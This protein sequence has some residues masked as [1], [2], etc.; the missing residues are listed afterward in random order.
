MLVVVEHT[1]K[2]TA[3]ATLN[4]GRRRQASVYVR[5]KYIIDSCVVCLIAVCNSMFSKSYRLL[6]IKSDSTC[7]TGYF[8]IYCFQRWGFLVTRNKKLCYLLSSARRDADNGVTIIPEWTGHYSISSLD[9]SGC[10]IAGKY[11]HSI[12]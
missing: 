3:R 7:F 5:D 10:H 6:K 9:M 1:H 2:H 4:C 8:Y 12:K 11:K